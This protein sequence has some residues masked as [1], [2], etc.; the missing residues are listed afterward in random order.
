MLSVVFAVKYWL[1]KSQVGGSDRFPQQ[2]EA[3]VET[4]SLTDLEPVQSTAGEATDTGAMQRRRQISGLSNHSTVFKETNSNTSTA[5]KDRLLTS[6]SN[7][8]YVVEV[9]IVVIIVVIVVIVILVV[10]LVTLVI[11]K[12]NVIMFAVLIDIV[13]IFVFES[14]IVVI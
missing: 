13:G 12:I 1:N 2:R 4:C 5:T 11:M 14:I 6:P 8:R 7:S 3:E 9:V 10:T